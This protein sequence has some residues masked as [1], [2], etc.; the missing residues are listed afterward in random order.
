MK[1]FADV[2]GKVSTNR[3]DFSR[4][5]YTD[6]QVSSHDAG[7]AA[8]EKFAANNCEPIAAPM[9]M[10]EPQKKETQEENK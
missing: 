7:I 10:T 6:A 5:N 8:V 3:K 4:G 2:V 1:R 9:T